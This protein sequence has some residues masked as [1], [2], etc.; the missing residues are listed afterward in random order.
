MWEF[1][2]EIFIHS[3]PNFRRRID[4]EFVQVSALLSVQKWF[5]R[6]LGLFHLLYQSVNCFAVIRFIVFYF[7]LVKIDRRPPF[8]TLGRPL[9]ASFTH[10][11]TRIARSKVNKLS[12]GSLS[13][14]STLWSS[15]S[16]SSSRAGFLRRSCVKLK[17]TI[18]SIDNGSLDWTPILFLVLRV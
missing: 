13:K 4:P 7:I 11:L 10:L 5:W 12:C 3:I 6:F 9:L 16:M 1:G 14:S 17:S 2:H 18:W 8:F 15:I